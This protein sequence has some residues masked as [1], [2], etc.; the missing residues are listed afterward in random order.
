MARI[1]VL[2][3]TA[4][5]QLGEFLCP[6]GDAMWREE[7]SIGRGWHV[8]FPGTSVWITHEGDRPIVA[9]PNHAVF[10]NDRQAY[11][12]DLISREGDR[13]VFVIAGEHLVR[14]ILAGIGDRGAD[15]DHP[16][17]GFSTGPLDQ[18][19]YLLNHRLIRHLQ[20]ERPE[21]LAV[22]EGIYH[23]LWRAVFAAAG[24]RAIGARRRSTERVHRD[25]VEAAKEILALH[26]A[27][28]ASLD[29]LAGELHV[30]PF[31]LAK[32]FRDRTGSTIHRY[33]VDLRLRT[34][35]HHL[36]ASEGALARIATELG[37]A[38]H[39]HFTG[40]FRRSFGVPPSAVRTRATALELEE[41]TNFSEA[42]SAP[43]P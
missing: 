19:T 23:I 5:L 3:E 16:V 15:L 18:Q 34:A 20:E 28:G 1:D 35:L 43:V 4:D 8:V 41:L 40:S 2:F 12:R 14:E 36:S 9:N 33:L 37:F 42:K 31:H 39:S 30:S 17:F 6:P 32:V 25:L 27:G 11:R 24:T 38:S 10:Y 7:N 29:R 22:R 13:C 26:L 21:F